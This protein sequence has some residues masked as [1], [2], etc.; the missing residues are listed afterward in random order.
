MSG[1]A[2]PSTSFLSQAFPDAATALAGPLP[3]VSTGGAAQLPARGAPHHDQ[4]FR[5]ALVHELRAPLQALQGNV[6]CLAQLA[7]ASVGRVRAMQAAIDVLAGTVNDVLALAQTQAGRLPLASLPFLLAD[8]LRDEVSLFDDEATTKGLTLACKIDADVPRW[9]RGDSLRL[10]QALRGLL[11]N[12]IKFT[13]DG[14]VTLRAS[15]LAGPDEAGVVSLRLSVSD[16][17]P[18]LPGGVSSTLFEPFERGSAIGGGTGLGLWMTR[19]WTTQMGGTVSATN[20]PGGGACLAIELALPTFKWRDNGHDSHDS[21]NCRD[22]EGDCDR[23]CH[24]RQDRVVEADAHEHAHA[25]AVV[26]V[27]VRPGLRALVV[28][29][30]PTNRR[31]LTAQLSVLGC[32]VTSAANSADALALAGQDAFDVVLTDI[33]LGGES[34]LALASRLRDRMLADGLAAPYVVAV[35]GDVTKARAAQSAGIDTVLAKPVSA[36]RLRNVLAVRWPDVAGDVAVPSCQWTRDS[37]PSSQS[38]HVIDG[39]DGRPFLAD[40][41]DG[42]MPWGD[43]H[44]RVVMRTEMA[45]DMARF[46]RLLAS[47]SA[48]D[49]AAATE[50]LHRMEGA[51]RVY[52]DRALAVRCLSRAQQLMRRRFRPQA[53]LATTP[54]AAT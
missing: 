38:G 41:Q 23:H 48:I 39:G 22:S 9:L 49:L 3:R 8:N 4:A 7:E 16:T 46:R 18:G 25:S 52:G 31:S 29:D 28:D 42:D 6:D 1:D 40:A 21:H 10:R 44:A 30:H 37:A 26:P 12:A 53:A 32:H 50:V 45:R 19:L 13:V 2:T 33:H 51:C 43:P 34:G 11:A 36:A 14:G 27:A 5:A 20:R 47:G 54:P 17:G 35:T 15:R 24:D